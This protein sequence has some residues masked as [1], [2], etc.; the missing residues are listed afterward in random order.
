MGDIF[1]KMKLDL[2]LEDLDSTKWARQADIS[3]PV[4][5]I[6]SKI[7]TT[8]PYHMGYKVY[9]PIKSDKKRIYTGEDFGHCEFSEKYPEGFKNLMATF[10]E[11]N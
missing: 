5:V 9:D 7:D 3:C 6:N 1:L 10:L 4:L 8:T 11:K 2:D